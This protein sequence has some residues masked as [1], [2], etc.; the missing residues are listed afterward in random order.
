MSTR[1]IL[2]YTEVLGTTYHVCSTCG[3]LSMLGLA[4][5]PC[6]KLVYETVPATQAE[7]EQRLNDK[8]SLCY[9]CYIGEW[10]TEYPHEP[11]PASIVDGRVYLDE[12]SVII[13]REERV[14]VGKGVV[15]IDETEYQKWERSLYQAKA[16]GEPVE[17]VYHR[18]YKSTSVNE[19]VDMEQP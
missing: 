17:V 10:V 1:L 8:I 2:K 4:Y 3:T 11:I 18:L 15:G 16:S 9:G 19:V 6:S 5:G 13:S 14:V 12:A 7:L